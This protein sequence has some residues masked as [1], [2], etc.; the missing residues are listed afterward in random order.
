MRDWGADQWSALAS[1]SS[2]VLALFVVF[3]TLVSVRHN[4]RMVA[5]ME[6][7]RLERSTPLLL[8]GFHIA[9]AEF[10]VLRLRNFGGPAAAVRV[11]FNPLLMNSRDE[12]VGTTPLLRG[13]LPLLAPDDERQV[14]F[15]HYRRF[16]SIDY[17]LGKRVTTFKATVY[18]RNPASGTAYPPASL[19]LDLSPL[20]PVAV[21]GPVYSALLSDRAWS[22]RAETSAGERAIFEETKAFLMA[23]GVPGSSFFEESA[24]SNELS[25]ELDIRGCEVFADNWSGSSR[26]VAVK[27]RGRHQGVV[28]KADGWS[29]HVALVLALRKAMEIDMQF[30]E[31][32]RPRGVLRARCKTLSGFGWPRCRQL[33]LTC[34]DTTFAGQRDSP[35]NGW[36]VGIRRSCRP[37]RICRS[38]SW[39]RCATS[40]PVCGRGERSPPPR[41]MCAGTGCAGRR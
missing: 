20:A 39:C 9:P 28:V 7:E 2:S 13:E 29:A 35:E 15:D 16:F 31:H 11:A 5:E 27:R 6:K 17:F 12:A 18:A 25:T 10:I 14:R 26:L 23:E 4:G 22:W 8:L 24:P 37:L 38:R 34:R 36:M 30:R 1:V 33:Q 40:T 21:T 32:R 19:I 3:L 41:P